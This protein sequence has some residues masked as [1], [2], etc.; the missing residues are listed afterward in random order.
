MSFQPKML[1]ASMLLAQLA[2]AAEPAHLEEVVVTGVGMDAPLTVVTDPKAPQQP[3]PVHD[4]ADYLK[5]IPGFSVI[6]KGGSDGDPVF[7]GM[8]GSRLGMLMDGAVVLGGCGARMDPPTAYVFPEAYDRITVIKGPQTVLYGPG[9]ATGTVLFERHHQRRADTGWSVNGSLLGGSADRNDEV[10]DVSGGTPDAYLRGTVTNAHQ[11]D[12]RDGHG[13]KVHSQYERWSADAAAGWTPNDD[14]LLELS[15]GHSDGEAAY[16]DRSVDGSLFARDNAGLKLELRNLG[17]V[18][19]KLEVQ[20]Y[21]NYIDHVMD[22]YSLRS[23]P[24]M[25]AMPAA[26]NPDRKTVGGRIAGTLDPVAGMQIILGVDTQD[27]QHTGRMSMNQ[28]LQR[29]QDLPREDDAHFNQVGVFAE[30]TR[31]LPEGRR[32]IAGA[33]GDDWYARDERSTIATTMMSRVANP[34][35]G[36]ERRETLGSGFLRYERDL[37]VL[38]GTAY[39]GIGHSERFPDYWE[40]F[41]RESLYSVS[42]FDAEAE[43]TNQFDAG[44]VYGKGPLKGS[45][46]VFYNAIGSFLLA[47]NGII[48]PAG[49][50]GTRTTA[51]TRNIDANSWGAE[52]D[53]IYALDEHWKINASLASVRGRNVTDGTALA[54]LAPLELRLGLQYANQYWSF[55]ALWRGVAEQVHVDPGR[56][57]IAG[58]DIG[59]T[60]GFGV[61]SVNAGWKPAKDWQ[62][63]AG[64][65]NLFDK[66]YAEHLSRSGAMVPGFTQTGRVNEPG[67]T[68]WLKVQ[69]AFR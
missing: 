1:F 8:A 62:L 58:Q 12:Y 40:L 50:M 46:S 59:P 9:H 24:G 49:M 39:A 20:A 33:R 47:E 53:A 2:W 22:N 68:G 65:D 19:K 11:G 61:F 18:L 3:L 15:G 4:G 60:A 34:T 16:A 28:N 14:T 27:N 43:K 13:N 7:R 25:M 23:L 56:G 35:Y 29:Y 5:T 31:Q 41:S 21:Y 55:G 51:V 64:I 57:N 36:Q 6:R 66:G 67:R 54:Q 10:L 63:T 52:A 37:A 26:M 44:L 32:V 42:A 48:K 69:L 17:A 45:I 30:L 38:P